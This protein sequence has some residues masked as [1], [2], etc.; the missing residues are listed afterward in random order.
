MSCQCVSVRLIP[1]GI[2]MYC[3]NWLLV[4]STVLAKLVMLA[5][6]TMSANTFF[7]FNS[8]QNKILPELDSWRDDYEE[9]REETDEM[10]GT[11]SPGYV[12]LV[13]LWW[14]G[15]FLLPFIIISL[16]Q[17]R[18]NLGIF[19]TNPGFLFIGVFSHFHIGPAQ[20]SNGEGPK[21]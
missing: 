20:C 2:H 11:L 10:K 18:D 8:S 1:R 17:N 15:V 21:R 4:I 12:V 13:V 7:V 14:I 16:V 6:C 9:I 3:S 19:K 5:A